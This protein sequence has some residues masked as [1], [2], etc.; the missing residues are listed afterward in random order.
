MHAREKVPR[1]TVRR[2]SLYLREASRLADAGVLTINSRDLGQTL[3]LTDAQIRKDLAY[4]GQL[5][6][7]GVG[8]QVEELQVRLREVLGTDRVWNAV[9][10]GAGNIGRALMNYGRFDQAGFHM[11]AVFDAQSQI[12]G[13][14]LAGHLVKPMRELADVVSTADVQIG[15]VAVPAEHAQAAADALLEAG[16]QGILNFAPIRL[17]RRRAISIVSV[18]LTEALEQL[19]FRVSLQRGDVQD[20]VDPAVT[21][22]DE[23]PDLAETEDE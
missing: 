16:I 20:P 15:V 19:A 6:H 10:I 2:L 11:V 9:V 4:L 8:Y 13:T 14:E 21:E 22:Q 5:G 18:S 23:A 1:P 12:V 7:P 3:G 17:E